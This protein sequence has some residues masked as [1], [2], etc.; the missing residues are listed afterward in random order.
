MGLS[1]GYLQGY[2][3]SIVLF[4]LLSL[5]NDVLLLLEKSISSLATAVAIATIGFFILSLVTLALFVKWQVPRILLVLPLY[6]I[7]STIL[8]L[9]GGIALGLLNQMTATTILAI[10]VISI[11]SALFQIGF[12]I[13]LIFHF[14]PDHF[15]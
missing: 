6:L 11:L 9:A 2:I 10:T 4:A 14:D 8:F 12:S 1:R 13:Y 7:I 5:V 15:D 3:L